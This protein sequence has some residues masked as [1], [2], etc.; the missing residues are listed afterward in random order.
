MEEKKDVKKIAL[1]IT[2]STIVLALI[3]YGSYLY[4]QRFSSKVILPNGQTYTGQEVTSAQPVVA[5]TFTAGPE[6]IWK[7]TK[8]QVYPYVLNYPE[9]LNVAIFPNDPTDSI[10]VA[11]G[12]IPPQNNILLNVE[13]ISSRNPEYLGKTEEYVRNWWRFF[14][15]L[16]GVESVVK[17]NNA[18]GLVGYKAKFI[19]SAD[20][21]PNTDV[22][23]EIP[24]DNTRVIHLA[25]GILDPQ[26]FDR[27]VDSLRYEK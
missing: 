17:F 27:M 23:F 13:T 7:D 22:F 14:N 10:A 15:G 9:T 26:I 21:T 6:V 4:S 5:S 20:Q 3:V 8:G 12:N 2:L 18:S 25:N 1:G 19:N 16:K 11:W 24:N